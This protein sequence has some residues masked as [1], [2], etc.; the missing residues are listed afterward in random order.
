MYA[1]R[2]KPLKNY[3]KRLNQLDLKNSKSISQIVELIQAHIKTINKGEWVLGFGW[4]QN[5]WNEQDFPSNKI[6]DHP[7][8]ITKGWIKI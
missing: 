8:K 2:G 5:L 3:G 7:S 6:L 4:D 1:G